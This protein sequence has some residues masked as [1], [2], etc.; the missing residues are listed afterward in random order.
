MTTSLGRIWIAWCSK[1]QAAPTLPLPSLPTIIPTVVVVPS[2][3][4]APT[5]MTMISSGRVGGY[6][7]RE[8]ELEREKRRSEEEATEVWA[9]AGVLGVG[10]GVGAGADGGAGARQ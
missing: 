2:R 3:N 1:Q 7:W 8:V 9:D 5:P 10:V 6:Y 4:H